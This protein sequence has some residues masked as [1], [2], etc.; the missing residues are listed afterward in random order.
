M[1][2]FIFIHTLS[3]LLLRGTIICKI[4][5]VCSAHVQR[6]YTIS[7]FIRNQSRT[8]LIRNQSFVKYIGFSWLIVQCLQGT[9]NTQMELLKRNTQ[10]QSCPF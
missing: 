2:I 8:R 6:R 4:I 9:W 5:R 7:F 3:A 1:M 10:R